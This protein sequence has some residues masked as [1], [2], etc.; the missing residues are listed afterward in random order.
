M[1]SIYVHIPFCTS[2]CRYC[3]FPSQAAP[4]E[5]YD[6]YVKALLREIILKK[7][8]LGTFSADTIYFGGGTPSLLSAEQIAQIL[9]ALKT[10]FK[11]TDTA[12]ITLEANPGTVNLTK[13]KA[14]KNIGINR[15]S[16]GV[17][18]AQNTLLKELGRIH[19]VEDAKK[20]IDNAQ[21][22]RFDNISLDLMYGLPHQTLA[23]LKESVDWLI[24]RNPRHI[25][26]YGLQIEKGTPF[27]AMQQEGNLPLPND[28]TIEK[29][30]DYITEELPKCGFKRY[31]I[32]NFAQKNYESRHNLGY[33]QD[34]PYVGFGCAAH[35]YYNFKRTYNEHNIN[36]YI[37][38][39]NKN[40]L[41]IFEEEKFNTQTWMEEF[42]FLALRTAKG[43]DKNKFKTNFHRDIHAVYDKVIE[44]LL[45]Q[46]LLSENDNYIFLT[47]LG[48]KFGNQVFEK[49]LL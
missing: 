27:F 48:M 46:K 14:L 17:Q 28:E 1:F 33:W 10:A 15:L 31:E 23:M 22:A 43:I 21:T 6:D 3:D 7:Q 4:K 30:Y 5:L 25:S 45:A 42:C 26:I 41:P 47:P 24:N 44:Q 34:K 36:L 37:K 38:A 18:A 11:V 35:S 13:L 29:M 40:L 49:F 8:Q 16:F 12:E 9:N 20:A 19:T 39:C 32:A 2:K